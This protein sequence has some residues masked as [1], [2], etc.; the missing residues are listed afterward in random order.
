M[1]GILRAVGIIPATPCE[2]NSP[3]RPCL[4]QG[5]SLGEEAVLADSGRAGEVAARVGWVRSLAFLSILRDVLLLPQTCRPSK[6]CCAK[7][8]FPQPAGSTRLTHRLLTKHLLISKKQSILQCVS[9]HTELLASYVQIFGDWLLHIHS[10]RLTLTW[11]FWQLDTSS[12][13]FD[14]LYSKIK[15]RWIACAN[16]GIPLAQPPHWQCISESRRTVVGSPA[17]LKYEIRFT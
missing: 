3:L 4:G 7:I 6:F 5:A 10:P 12:Y 2:V 9:M 14:E 16:W 8:V 17:L 13:C 15:S 1:G 11:Q